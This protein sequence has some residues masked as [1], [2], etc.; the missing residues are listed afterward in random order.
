MA[1][2]LSGE[3]NENIRLLRSETASGSTLQLLLILIAE[4]TRTRKDAIELPIKKVLSLRQIKDNSFT[5]CQ[6]KQDLQ[7]LNKVQF[8]YKKYNGAWIPSQIGTGIARR[9]KGLISFC[10]DKSF[11]ALIPHNQFMEVPEGILQ[12]QKNENMAARFMLLWRICQHKRMNLDKSNADLVP[13]RSLLDSCPAIP[14]YDSLKCGQ[15]DQRIIKPFEN[16]LDKC[17]YIF[18]WE[19]EQDVPENHPMFRQS[20]IQI[21]WRSDPYAASEDFKRAKARR[22]SQK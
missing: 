8:E 7:Y 16:A 22:R 10:F 5:R 3:N 13:V 6:I 11:L 19:Y 21:I 17:S 18:S 20:R 9:E 1:C 4:I 2:M 14:T 12:T 15:V